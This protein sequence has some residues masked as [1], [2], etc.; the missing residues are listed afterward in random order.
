[1][2]NWLQFSSN[3]ISSSVAESLYKWLKSRITI[4]IPVLCI[5]SIAPMGEQVAGRQ[6]KP[7]ANCKDA[8]IEGSGDKEQPDHQDI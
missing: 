3:R 2:H 7:S 6:N 1:M 4:N 5:D 8:G